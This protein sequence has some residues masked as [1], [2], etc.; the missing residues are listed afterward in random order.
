MRVIR[1][2]NYNSSAGRDIN[3]LSRGSYQFDD[4]HLID[5]RLAWGLK[6]GGADKLELS[7]ECFNALNKGTILDNYNRWGKYTQRHEAEW[8]QA[9]NY[10]DPYTIESPR[11][12][13]AGVRF[14]F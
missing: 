14:I 10:G 9:S 13:R 7:L 11:Q 6:L 8:T 12:V 3:L 1:G 4:R 5:L 2:L